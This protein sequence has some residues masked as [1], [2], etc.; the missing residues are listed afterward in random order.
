MIRIVV[1]DDQEMIRSGLKTILE[2][3]GDIEVVGEAGDGE[4]VVDVVKRYT[5]DL[6]L[7]DIRMPKVDGIEATRRL[8]D[9]KVLILTTF[10]L[11]EYVLR[12]LVAG[13]S[14]F[15]LKDATSEQL[16]AA[17]RAVY[18]GDSALSKSVTQ[19]LVRFINQNNKD[20]LPPPP[21]LSEL[22]ARELEVLM[23]IA[24]GL[25]NQEIGSELF[26][27]EATVKTHVSKLLYK[28]QLRDRV[29]AVVFVHKYGILS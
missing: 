16:V 9:S 25:S 19:T 24:K 18:S 17:V 3:E 20:P 4:A 8:K 29:Q 23:L 10:H 22:T 15:L 14:G 2:A 6:V 26:L 27:S 5:P 1:A 7:M 13:A 11:D 21:R 28:L 12:A